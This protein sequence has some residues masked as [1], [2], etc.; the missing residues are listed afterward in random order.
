M[1]RDNNFKMT[2]KIGALKVSMIFIMAVLLLSSGLMI[3]KVNADVGVATVANFKE[4]SISANSNNTVDSQSGD[5]DYTNLAKKY[6]SYFVQNSDGLYYLD[7]RKRGVVAIDEADREELKSYGI[8]V[9]KVNAMI[10]DGTLYLAEDGNYH[11]VGV[12]VG[13]RSFSGGRNDFWV[14]W[15]WFLP[16]GYHIELSATNAFIF[17]AV[18]GFFAFASSFIAGDYDKFIDYIKKEGK[19]TGG[20]LVAEASYATDF[21]TVLADIWAVVSTLRFIKDA[22]KVLMKGGGIAVIV[23]V[24]VDIVLN[25]VWS[26]AGMPFLVNS[27]KCIFTSDNTVVVEPNLLFLSNSSWTTRK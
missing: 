15:W 22:F 5:A 4:Q 12:D 21:L 27:L 23:G 16:V 2:K 11:A 7:L 26:N 20:D 10:A 19:W 18:S 24:I 3:V 8:M 6:F 13:S 25:L 14:R 17:G 1:I 9:D